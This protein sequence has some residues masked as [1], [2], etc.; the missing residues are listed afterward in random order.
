MHRLYTQ[1]LVVLFL[2]TEG[3]GLDLAQSWS[4]GESLRYKYEHGESSH[5]IH[6]R[7]LGAALMRLLISTRSWNARAKSN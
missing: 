4:T 6:R 7:R 5:L 2:A 1:N 3:E